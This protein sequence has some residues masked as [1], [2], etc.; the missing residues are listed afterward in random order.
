MAWRLRLSG[1]AVLAERF[2][3]REGEIDIVAKRGRTLRFIEVKQRQKAEQAVEPVTARSEA[4]I[5]RASEVWMARHP[6]IMERCR[7]LRYDIVTVTGRGRV[8]TH[9]DAF[10]GW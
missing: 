4:R 7:E 6:R 9:R 10:R 3:C 8:H 5:L 2:R 1:H